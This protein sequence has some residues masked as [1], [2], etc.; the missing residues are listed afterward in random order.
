MDLS[1]LRV[2]L[3]VCLVAP[4]LPASANQSA[5]D[6]LPPVTCTACVLVDDDGDVLYARRPYRRLPNASTTKMLT[7]LIVRRELRPHALVEVSPDAAATGGGGLDLAAGERFRVTALLQALLLTS[8]ND[9]AVALAEAAGGTEERFVRWMNDLAATLGATDTAYVTAHGLDAPGHGSSAFDLALI[10]RRLLGDPLL[11]RIV[12]TPAA[13]IRGS[14]GIVSLENRNLLLQTYPGAIGV[15]TGYTAA[16]GNVLVAAARRQGRTLVAV[17]M[18]S[19]DATADGAVLLDL[20]FRKLARAV[21]LQEDAPVGAV[22]FDPAGSTAAVAAASLR[23]MHHPDRI[24]IVFHPRRSLRVPL[25][26]G[27]RVGTISV[28]ARRRVV[29]RVPAIAA[30]QVE[31]MRQPWATGVISRVLELAG[32]LVRG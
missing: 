9:A 18:G 25:A 11:A 27:E 24:E 13:R 1:T 17:A 19:V 5:R 3:V 31:A 14:R 22:V 6:V 32:T 12:A 2:A 29:G 23:G 8:S 4:W 26:P 28:R 20:G 7:A 15:K 16:A 21:L 30:Q 10:A